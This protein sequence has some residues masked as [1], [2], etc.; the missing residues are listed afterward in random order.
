[1]QST[2]VRGSGDTSDLPF[3]HRLDEHLQIFQRRRRMHPV[4]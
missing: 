4:S 3:V 1:M 2:P